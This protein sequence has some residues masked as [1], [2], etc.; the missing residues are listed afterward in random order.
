MCLCGNKQ[1]TLGAETHHSEG[2]NQTKKR[3]IVSQS[4]AG[5]LYTVF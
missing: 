4:A 5:I 1:K 2:K 3:T